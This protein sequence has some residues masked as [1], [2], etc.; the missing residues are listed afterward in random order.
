MP[1]LNLNQA[2]RA[3]SHHRIIA[4]LVAEVE[5]VHVRAWVETPQHA[6]YLERGC[7]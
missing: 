3:G 5:K 1:I 7:G 6:V 2:F 4:I